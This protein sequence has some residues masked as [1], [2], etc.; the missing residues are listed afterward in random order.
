[1]IG[2]SQPGPQRTDVRTAR[3]ATAGVALRGWAA[4]TNWL[5]Q[6]AAPYVPGQLRQR[7][8]WPMFA[9]F[10]LSLLVRL[11]FVSNALVNWDAVQF[12]LATRSF[13]IARHQPHPPGYILYIGW[14]RML[15]WLTGD[16]NMAFVLTSVF[17]SSLAVAMLY[18]LGRDLFGART[19]LVAAVL[20]AISPLVWYYSIVA[21]T[22]AVETFFLLLVVWLCWRALVRPAVRP[23][24]LAALILGLAGG[25]RQS[26]LVLLLPLWLYVGWRAGR[27]ALVRGIATLALTCLAWFVPLIWL[28]GGPLEYLKDG[29]SLLGFVGSK[30]SVISGGLGAVANNLGQV[31]GGLLVGLNLGILLPLL[32]VWR[33]GALR[34]RL[35]LLH[36]TML[37]LWAGPALA[38]FVLGHIGQVGYLLLILPAACLLLALYVEAAGHGLARRLRLSPTGATAVI[39]GVLTVGNV[40]TVALAPQTAHAVLG[41][42]VAASMVDVRDN[43][44]FWEEVPAFLDRFTPQEA[45]VLAEASPW[46]SFRHA[47]YYLTGYRVYGLGNDRFGHFGWLY[48]SYGGLT[49]YSLEGRA[50]RIMPRPTAARYAIVL[51]PKIVRT[52]VQEAPTVEVLAT[53]YRS[54]W[55]VDLAGVDSLT[56]QHGRTFLHGAVLPSRE[57]IPFTLRDLRVDDIR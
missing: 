27:P 23:V 56:F 2:A 37:C 18:V 51:D 11:P 21:L 13:D 44:R 15:T 57:E 36:W 47:G 53:G 16:A 32:A 42:P 52:I 10:L 55:V 17:A 4:L 30:T 46:G 54:I 28:A 29:L 25:V 40:V 41:D 38:T 43:D 5:A 26:T 48:E 14:G 33:R 22:Y 35:T 6:R 50:R 12:A 39:V 19:A 9:L 24:V 31:A 49:D 1:M 45:I 8:H 34:P 7:C 20:F 3:D